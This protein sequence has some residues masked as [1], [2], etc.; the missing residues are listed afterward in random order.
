MAEENEHFDV[1]VVIQKTIII[2]SGSLNFHSIIL[3]Y[4]AIL[5]LEYLYRIL[6]VI[7][8]YTGL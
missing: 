8:E 5:N 3:L 4:F 2:I 1:F 6:F 7:Y